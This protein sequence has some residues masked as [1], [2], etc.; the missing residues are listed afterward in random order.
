MRKHK[1]EEKF[2]CNFCSLQFYR[3]YTLREHCSKVHKLTRD[4]MKKSGMYA[5]KT[6]LRE[7]NKNE[8][9]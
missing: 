8:P 2:R 5:L 6:V 7:T 1:S 3:M 9:I 4:D